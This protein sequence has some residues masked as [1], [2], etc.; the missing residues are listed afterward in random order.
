MMSSNEIQAT[1]S[2]I[3]VSIDAAA[4]MIGLGRT[5]FYKLLASGE[6]KSVRCGGRV[7]IPVDQ[8]TAL[9]ERLEHPDSTEKPSCR[10]IR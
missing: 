9:I 3:A 4:K 2:P 10:S 5:S 7:L 1:L 6:I 8:L